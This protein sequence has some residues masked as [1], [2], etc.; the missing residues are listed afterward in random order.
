MIANR[1]GRRA[2]VYGFHDH[3]GHADSVILAPSESRR[4]SFAAVSPGTFFYR[5]RTTTAAVRSAGRRTRNS[6]V[7]SSSTRRTTAYAPTNE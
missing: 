1:L 6:P 4:V 5:A 2:V 3:D 7:P